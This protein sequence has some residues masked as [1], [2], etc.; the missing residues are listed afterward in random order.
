MSTFESFGTGNIGWDGEEGEI[1]RI[2]D[3]N[4]VECI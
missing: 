4:I 1:A 3:Q 2:S